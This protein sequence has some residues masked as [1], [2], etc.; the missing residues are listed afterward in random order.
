MT[1]NPHA[2]RAAACFEEGFSCSQ[3]V[4]S[5]YGEMFA[6]NR[7]Q[8][9][10]LSQAFGGGMARMGETCGA[11]TG[12]FMAIGL[13]YGRTRAEDEAARDKTYA[14][15]LDF[16]RRFKARHGSIVC[17][18]LIGCDMGTAEGLKLA[19]DSRVIQTRCPAFIRA[20]TEILDEIL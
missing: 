18:E 15:V 9:L 6:L 14:L 8:A 19:H 2:D 10:K 5:T 13:K 7:E 12:A 4:L 3:A 1:K 16:V 17:K 20:A 11:V